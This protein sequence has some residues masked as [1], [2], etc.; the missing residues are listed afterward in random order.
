MKVLRLLIFII[1]FLPNNLFG[2]D[3]IPSKRIISFGFDL[4]GPVYRLV[5]PS[6][7][8]YE[9]SVTIGSYRNIFP[10]LEAGTLKVNRSDSS[11][12]YS[13]TGNF[14][15]IGAD[16]NIFK[17]KF[18]KDFYMVFFG[19][20]YGIA[21]LSHSADNIYIEDNVWGDQTNK[22][23]PLSIPATT[24]NAQWVE[25]TGGIRAEIFKNFSVG[26]LPSGINF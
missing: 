21:K 19:G 3:S 2:Q 11:F 22:F 7:S 18:V 12:H 5:N 23:G 9:G 16:Y 1:Y 24:V 17:R 14:M 20:R 15:C 8:N 4:Y 26:W 13:S 10:T 6:V 25:F